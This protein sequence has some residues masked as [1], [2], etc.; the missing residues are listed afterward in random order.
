MNLRYAVAASLAAVLAIGG[1]VEGRPKPP[2]VVE[3]PPPPP[4]PA[5]PV[6]LPSRLLAD[7]AAYQ[8]FVERTATPSPPFANGAAV[9][10]ALKDSTAYEPEALIRGAVAYAAVAALEDATFV[11][12]VRNAG[13]TPENRHL[14]VGYLIADPRY[15][16]LFRGADGAAGLA[17]QALAD[18]GRRLY[19]RGRVVRQSSY[20]IQ[21]QPW[22][23]E[24]VVDRGGRLAA[25]EAE[26]RAPLPPAADRVD[27]LQK[28]T[29]GAAPLTIAAAPAPP[30]YTP[31]VARAVQIA[32][33]AALGEVGEDSYDQLA[34][35]AVD[36]GARGCL[37]M[38]KLNLYQCLAVAKP[39]YED[40]FCMGQHS[41]ADAGACLIRNAGV[42]VPV[43]APAPPPV[44]AA[45]RVPARQAG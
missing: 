24:E 17:R 38:A 19:E 43:D 40:V 16:L 34:A 37:H 45:A 36:E 35:L 20:D 7:A 18:G 15:A 5:G 27:A 22:S 33:I 4:P 6:S 30:P 11:A 44:P 1:A 3:A 23:K 12:E 32:A 29:S 21:H 25:V 31:L 2:P 41:M 13:N 14:M 9:A 10:Q 28:A 42:S 8:A 26:G 39:H